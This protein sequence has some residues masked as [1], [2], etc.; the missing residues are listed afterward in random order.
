MYPESTLPTTPSDPPSL[1]PSPNPFIEQHFSVPQAHHKLVKDVYT[2][3]VL[4]RE[5]HRFL[6]LSDA[7]TVWCGTYN[8][9]GAQPEED[10]DAW[11]D[12]ELEPVLS[13][14]PDAAAMLDPALYVLAFQEVD[15]T[16]EAYLYS[17]GGLRE[18]AWSAKVEAALAKRTGTYTKVASKQLVGLLILV[19]ANTTHLPTIPTPHTTSVGVGF[20]RMGNKGCTAVRLRVHDSFFTFVNCHL[21]A[22]PGGVE[23]RNADFADVMRKAQ[24][25]WVGVGGKYGNPH[26]TPSSTLHT[27]AQTSPLYKPLLA[28]LVDERAPEP[29]GLPPLPESVRILGWDNRV[30][31]TLMDSDHLIFLGDLNYRL[32]LPP[33]LSST[34]VRTK[35]MQG[36]TASLLELDQLRGEIARG[37]AFVGFKE[38]PVTFMPTYKYDVGTA[39]WDSSEKKRTPAWCD[40]VVYYA[41]AETDGAGTDAPETGESAT[42]PTTRA[43]RPNLTPL[44][45]TSTPELVGSD[46]KP[47]KCIF[48]ARAR[49]IDEEKWG[50]V[51][52]EA[53]RELD[54]FEN[55][56]VPV[57]KVST[58][59][60]DFGPVMYAIPKSQTLTIANTG[61]VAARFRFVPPTPDSPLVCPPWLWPCPS[62]GALLPGESVQVRVTCT[63]FGAESAR[64]TMGTPGGAMDEILVL[65]CDDAR[66]DFI[67]VRGD[68]TP[69]CFGLP[70]RVLNALPAPV[71]TLGSAGVRAVVEDV[72][73]AAGKGGTNFPRDMWRL[74][75]FV[76]RYRGECE[77]VFVRGGDR[78]LM[79]Y[80]RE[81]LDTGDEFDVGRLFGGEKSWAETSVEERAGQEEKGAEAEEESEA[82]VVSEGGTTENQE[83]T[84]NSTQTS[85]VATINSAVSNSGQT[86]GPPLLPSRRPAQESGSPQQSQVSRRPRASSLATLRRDLAVHSVAQTLL[87]MLDALPG[88]LVPQEYFWK[89]VK[90]GGKGGNQDQQQVEP[91]QP[92][93]EDPLESGIGEGWY[94]VWVN[95]CTLVRDVAEDGLSKERTGMV[96]ELAA[97]FA[98]VL[99]RPPASALDV[100][101]VSGGTN[102]LV[103][104][105]SIQRRRAWFARQFDPRRL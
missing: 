83:D 89:V 55:E 101:G 64:L 44:V 41:P 96:E 15:L 53:A 99:L 39:E 13:P 47:V 86:S 3:H 14:G 50:E 70:L 49:V 30:W 92:V 90:Q 94:N 1:A 42:T 63:V 57:L 7:F 81:C 19:Y 103:D 6:R 46:H 84:N 16:T 95:L 37:R 61:L 72:K 71:R 48:E 66:D 2:A 102:G 62:S 5:E 24:V 74:V 65:R 56:A 18:A 33:T 40:R 9:A 17:D 85:D 59:T 43:P 104:D 80:V 4:R 36:D 12:P 67:S 77:G 35:L 22:D 11:L 105:V 32:T 76:F 45:Y 26:Y 98:P 20:L 28:P 97:V 27:S 51:V 69:T 23:R 87:L 79:E 82:G 88:G 21:A 78:G 73:K 93:K 91:G 75:D 54:R 29:E 68:W 8:V 38:A 60:L 34:A 58:N 25:E 52:Q 10:L 31:A 100:T